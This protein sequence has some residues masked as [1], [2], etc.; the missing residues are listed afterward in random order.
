MF[1]QPAGYI[2]PDW[3]PGLWA[4]DEDSSRSSSRNKDEIVDKEFMGVDESDPP[5]WTLSNEGIQ[6][7]K[8]YSKNTD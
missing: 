3:V 4:S 2:N 6:M 1:P 8:E 7:Y 5:T